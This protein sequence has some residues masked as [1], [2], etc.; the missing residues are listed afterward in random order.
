MSCFSTLGLLHLSASLQ[1]LTS[2]Y[3][4]S[5]FS[6][7]LTWVRLDR[8]GNLP[9][10]KRWRG[11][12]IAGGVWCV[13]PHSSILSKKL[14]GE[15]R[16]LRQGWHCLTVTCFHEA[17]KE[18]KCVTVISFY[19]EFDIGNIDKIVNTK[20]FCQGSQC[21]CWDS[22][23]ARPEWESGALPL[24]HPAQ[25]N[26]SIPHEIWVPYSDENEDRYIVS[27]NAVK[28]CRKFWRIGANYNLHLQG[29]CQISF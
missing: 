26:I 25:L 12:D 10:R 6:G 21:L 4:H 29:N 5:T 1:A 13:N 14:L 27:S 17:T 19:V 22:K 18:N 24:G 7:Y 2:C 28:Y 3:I 20:N 15:E 8:C 9:G 23:G 11:C 16:W